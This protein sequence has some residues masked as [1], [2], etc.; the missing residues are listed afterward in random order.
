MS[1]TSKI[2]NSQQRWKQKATRRADDNRY[3]RKELERFKRE[4]EAYKKRAKQAEARL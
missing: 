1:A 2:K 3:L 4:R